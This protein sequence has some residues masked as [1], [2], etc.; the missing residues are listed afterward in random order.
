MFSLG[1][2]MFD[3]IPCVCTHPLDCEKMQ[4]I[5]TLR[6]DVVILE[7]KINKRKKTKIEHSL[8]HCHHTVDEK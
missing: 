7:K 4:S 3:W 6:S 5:R 8:A 1:Q 2:S